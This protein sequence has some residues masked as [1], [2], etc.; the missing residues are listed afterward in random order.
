MPAV[1]RRLEKL[2]RSTV[3]ASMRMIP[4]MYGGVTESE[5]AAAR[6]VALKERFGAGPIPSNLLEIVLTGRLP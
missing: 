4:V 2:E 6:E 3:A 5:I 1:E